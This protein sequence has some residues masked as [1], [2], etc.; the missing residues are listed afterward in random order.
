M[1]TISIDP[2]T[3]IEGHLS[4]KV[5]VNSF[6]KV[7]SARVS[8]NLF[9]DF[10]NILIGRDAND[11]VHITQRICG[12]CP[13][14]HAIAAS[15]TVES[16]IGYTPTAQAQWLRS[17]IHGADFAQDHILHFYHLNLMD[18]V[19][20]PDMPPWSN[21][22]TRDVRIT[23]ADRDRLIAHYIQAL[24]TRRRAQ[25]MI[26]LLAGK[27]PHVATVMPG[28]VTQTPTAAQMATFKAYLAELRSFVRDVYV[29]DAEFVASKYPDYFRVGVRR[30]N[31]LSFGVFDQPG[32]PTLFKRGRI[33]QP[34][35][36]IPGFYAL[37]PAG[38]TE[39]VRYSF[40]SGSPATSP[41]V[42]ATSPEIGKAGAYSWLKAPRY[43]GSE[44]E[45]GPLAR[46]KVNG[47]YKGGVSVM[48]RM[49]A[50]AYEARKIVD[51]MVGWTAKVKPGALSF[52]GLPRVNAA[53]V[54]LTEA[55]RGALGH[56]AQFKTGKVARYQIVT[57]TCWNASP[58]DDRGSVGALEQA[59][60]GTVVADAAH[61]IE[62]M[63]IVHSFDPC[64]G[65]AVHV[66]D[67]RTGAVREFVTGPLAP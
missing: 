49:L 22:E 63:R 29:P 17:L 37:A 62:L 53:G 2:I 34:A 16:V 57:P 45:V 43:N 12:V 50:R 59:L 54:G 18:Y 35:G 52:S 11:P 44:Y 21:A 15:K 38:V 56:W 32:G 39:A 13:V 26:A 28:G 55:P 66:T 9:R 51:A 58:R 65:C 4:L 61:P 47:D 30:Q 3:R 7:T 42:G 41:A 33:V 64:T 48:D 46:M 25:E 60:T 24:R 1:A 6:G 31:L 8:G 27:I 10:E 14:S 5:D 67:A 40:Y 19:A 36:G 20:G 23:G